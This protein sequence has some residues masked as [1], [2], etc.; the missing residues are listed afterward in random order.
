MPENSE[1]TRKKVALLCLDAVAKDVL[2]IE[3][4]EIRARALSTLSAVKDAILFGEIPIEDEPL[5][6]DQLKSDLRVV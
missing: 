3:D 1:P 5:I 2:H 6:D 4:V